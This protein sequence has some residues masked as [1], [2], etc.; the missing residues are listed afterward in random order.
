ME[1]PS[2]SSTQPAATPSL[3]HRSRRAIRSREPREPQRPK[4]RARIPSRLPFLRESR[5]HDRCRHHSRRVFVAVGR[6]SHWPRQIAWI[7][8]LSTC[9]HQTACLKQPP[10]RRIRFRNGMRS[11]SSSSSACFHARSAFGI[12]SLKI[13]NEI[14]S[15]ESR[16]IRAQTRPMPMKPRTRFVKHRRLAYRGMIRKPSPHTNPPDC[17]NDISCFCFRSRRGLA[18][19]SAIAIGSPRRSSGFSKKLSRSRSSTTICACNCNPD[20]T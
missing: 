11:S 10:H 16:K 7:L 18:H 3:Q 4:P 15:Y 17:L 8:L 1:K 9:G 2:Q 6:L 13:Q 12:L 5:H 19:H 14:P 20:F